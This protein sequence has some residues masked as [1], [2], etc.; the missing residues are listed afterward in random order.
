[1]AGNLATTNTVNSGNTQVTLDGG[2]A[3]TITQT[4]GRYFP[5]GL[6]TVN[7]SANTATLASHLTLNAS[8][9]LTITSGTLDFAGFNPTL[10][11]LTVDAT[12]TLQLQGGETVATTT[13]TLNSGSTVIYNGAGA[14]GSLLLGNS[15]HHLTFN[16]SGSWVHSGT[17]DVNG[18]LILTAGTLSSSGQ[19]ITLAGNWSNSG[20]YT[21]GSN[22]VTLDGTNQNIS[23]NT[24]F[25]N[26]T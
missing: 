20:T 19:N 14:Y 11:V 18:N 25:N 15:Y 23:G 13:T 22:T 21:S 6:F 17:L 9:D 1:M 2:N 8:Q 4:A 16:G 24:T 3:Q 10:D 12:G 26:L 5:G 7:K